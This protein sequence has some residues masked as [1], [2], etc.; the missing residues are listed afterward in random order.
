MSGTS[1]EPE[2][3]IQ[4]ITWKMKTNLYQIW[5][6]PNKKNVKPRWDAKQFPKSQLRKL[7]PLVTGFENKIDNTLKIYQDTAIYAGRVN[8]G[9]KLNNQ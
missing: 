3:F 7:K 8:K 6:F 4:S 2:L 1:A 9:K 5:M